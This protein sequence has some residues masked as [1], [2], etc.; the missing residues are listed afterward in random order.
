MEIGETPK[1]SAEFR[2]EIV[3]KIGTIPTSTPKTIRFLR[4]TNLEEAQAV[5]EQ[6]YGLEKRFGFQGNAVALSKDEEASLNEIQNT[7]RGAS[8]ALIFAFPNVRPDVMKL[9]QEGKLPREFKTETIFTVSNADFS[10]VR[11]SMVNQEVNMVFNSQFV[12][13]Y[14]DKDA[15]VWYPNLQYWENTLKNREKQEGWTPEEYAAHRQEM[16]GIL[17]QQAIQRLNEEVAIYQQQKEL[18]IVSLEDLLN[19]NPD[20]NNGTPPIRIP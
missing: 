16:Y 4:G 14:Y 18:N 10:S 20:N 12:E 15:K 9:V 17:R 3:D 19:I 7:H 11:T 13:G 5:S 1:P 8:V 2:Q 6:G